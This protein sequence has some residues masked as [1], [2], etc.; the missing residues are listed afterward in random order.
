MFL[1][2]LE[3]FFLSLYKVFLSKRKEIKSSKSNTKKYNKI[4]MSQQ[5]NNN[6]YYYYYYYLFICLFIFN[7]FHLNFICFLSYYQIVILQSV[8]V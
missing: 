4:L 1:N 5:N 8:T 2:I 6:N 3:C 7:L